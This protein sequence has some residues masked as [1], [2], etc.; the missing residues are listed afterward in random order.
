MN[1]N[2]R[3]RL[4]EAKELL[5]Q[6]FSIIEE[7]KDEEQEAYDN[8]PENLQSSE[9]SEDIEEYIDKLEDMCT[10]FEEAVM[11]LEEISQ[12]W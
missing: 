9:R 8:I 11:E 2:R 7:V 6:A 12:G 10:N 4:A 1:K 5:E 3:K